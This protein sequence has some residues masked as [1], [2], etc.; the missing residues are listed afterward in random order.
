MNNFKYVKSKIANSN[1]KIKPF[2]YFTIKNLLPYKELNKLNKILPSFNEIEDQ[3]IYHQVKSDTKKVLL[4]NS[5]IYK[6]LIKKPSFKKLNSLFEKL[7]PFILK[8]FDEP[9]KNFVNKKY[10]KS[11][12]TF[13]SVFSLMRKGYYLK[14]HIDRRE[15]L[16]TILF[17]P[18]SQVLKGGDI[19]L[20]QLKKNPNK[21][22]NF[23]VF[24]ATDN[25]KLGK[26]FKIKNNF[27]LF[28][29]NVPWSYHSVSKY[30]GKKDR[31]YFYFV[32]DFP[33]KDVG[34]KLKN[35]K[36]GNNQNTFWK[37]KV[38]VFSQ[39]RRKEFFQAK[40]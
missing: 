5:K 7:K 38:S 8:K 3:D 30:N 24:P 9:I 1:L 16:I 34:A 21:I 11:H 2:P 15:H 35:R 36:K 39:K 14:P 12:L 27:C 13:H 40:S 19:K 26:S 25:L 4:P 20:M 32:Y 33:T 6:K 23:D 18:S 17:Y 37:S 31:K 28:T 29:L 22:K 10:Q